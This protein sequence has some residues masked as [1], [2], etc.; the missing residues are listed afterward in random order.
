[1]N[2]GINNL[3]LA[4]LRLMFASCSLHQNSKYLYQAKKKLRRRGIII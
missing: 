4:H 1:M 2:N 3:F